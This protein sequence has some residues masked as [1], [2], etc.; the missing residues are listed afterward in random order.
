MTTVSVGET[1]LK[2]LNITLFPNPT[3]GTFTLDLGEQTQLNRIFITDI[4]GRLIK[5]I[6]PQNAAQYEVNFDGAPGIYLLNVVGEN[7]RATLK[8]IKE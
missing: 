6:T 1:E 5:E 7:E 4:N 2:L 3:N 8:I